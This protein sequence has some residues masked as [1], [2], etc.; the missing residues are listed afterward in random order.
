MLNECRRVD[1]V[2]KK[3][4]FHSVDH[5]Y[6]AVFKEIFVF[7]KLHLLDVKFNVIFGNEVLMMAK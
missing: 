1:I 3:S 5:I 4:M 2:S 6:S 7:V